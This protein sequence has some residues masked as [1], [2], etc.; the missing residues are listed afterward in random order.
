MSE[1]SVPLVGPTSPSRGLF[2]CL[3]SCRDRSL[4]WSWQLGVTVATGDVR[5]AWLLSGTASIA[6]AIW[7]MLYSAMW[8]PRL[9]RPTR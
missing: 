8:T 1:A 5:R 3:S 9:P 7:S 4:P 2:P 6:I